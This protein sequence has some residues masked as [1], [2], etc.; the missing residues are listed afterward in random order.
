MDEQDLKIMQA[1]W[2]HI[3]ESAPHKDG[4]D[5]ETFSQAV[6]LCILPAW[7]PKL[8]GQLFEFVNKSKSGVV[9]LN[10]W[11]NM[12]ETLGSKRGKLRLLYG[13]CG[14]KGDPAKIASTISMICKCWRGGRELTPEEV[15]SIEKAQ[16]LYTPEKFVRLL[17]KQYPEILAALDSVK[18]KP[19]V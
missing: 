18:F 1:H 6:A 17:K 13:V 11:A 19:Q 2:A 12:I 14:D 3:F 7:E 10:E 4:V 9:S 16:T 15:Q 8:L 5:R